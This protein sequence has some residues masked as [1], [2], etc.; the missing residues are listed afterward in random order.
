ML[1]LRAL[2]DDLFNG[3]DPKQF[4]AAYLS[5]LESKNK[6]ISAP[7]LFQSFGGGAYAGFGYNGADTP[8]FKELHDLVEAAAARA[9][10]KRLQSEATALLAGLTSGP[11]NGAALYE[12][13][14]DEQ[15]Y[16]GHA[17]LHHIPVAQFADLLMADSKINDHVLASLAQRYALG[18]NNLLAAERPWISALRSELDRRVAADTAPFKQ[19]N[20]P[21]IAYTF[22]GIDKN[23]P[24]PQ[25]PAARPTTTKRRRRSR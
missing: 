14:L 13:G 23:F 17:I 7:D 19:W 22:D 12:C 16:A 10:D 25:T 2:G 3:A 1:R 24:A 21:R 6:L 11:P 5:D 8:E 15:K 18:A 4:V 20:Q 9:L